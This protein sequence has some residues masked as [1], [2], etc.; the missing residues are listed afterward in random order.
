MMALSIYLIV[1]IAGIIYDRSVLRFGT[2][3]K[4][5]EALRR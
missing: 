4:L 2:P 5:R 1:R 3:V